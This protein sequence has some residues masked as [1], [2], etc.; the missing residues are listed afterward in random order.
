LGDTTNGILRIRSEAAGAGCLTTL[1]ETT[2]ANNPQLIFNVA[3]LPV[4]IMKFRPSNVGTNNVFFA[5]LAATTDGQVADPNP[6]IGFTN[7]GGTTWTGRTT[8]GGVSANVA[9]TGQ[10]ISTANFALAKIEVVSATKI[11]FFIDNNVTDGINFTE[12]G[13]STT[14]IY[15]SNLAPQLMYQVRTGGTIN[16][17]LEVDY[18]R[19][20]QDDSIMI[21]EAGPE[22]VEELPVI[23]SVDEKIALIEG[24]LAT[25]TA[26]VAAVRLDLN[27]QNV[28]IATQQVKID[29]VVNSVNV[30]NASLDETKSMLAALDIRITVTE[31]RLDVD[32]AL[33][34]DLRTVTDNLTAQMAGLVSSTA[35]GLSVDLADTLSANS[36]YI[37]D[38][39]VFTGNIS[40][41]K[42]ATFSEDMVGQAKILAGHVS[43]TVSFTEPYSSL[44]IVSVTPMD[45]DGRWELSSVTE[46]SFR[47][48]IPE[49]LST[50]VLFNWYAFGAD[51]KAKVFVSDGTTTTIGFKIDYIPEVIPP[52]EEIVPTEEVPA[53][54][55]T[56]EG[57]IEPAL[58][59]ESLIVENPVET[60]D[61]TSSAESAITTADVA[62]AD[63]LPSSPDGATENSGSASGGSTTEAPAGS[64][65][66]APADSQ[67][68][69]SP[70]E[71]GL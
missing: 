57:I 9:C 44:P 41:G 17:Q 4:I 35:A 16:N 20:W 58:E 7:N 10:T 28:L 36:L 11:N 37:A 46:A 67:P 3:N 19:A 43:T 39:A 14:N 63:P 21:S 12:C 45:Y 50:D 66:P 26:D 70:A 51:G 15:T 34:S 65:E 55:S 53:V 29:E 18:Y 52:S 47:I 23:L 31:D 62:A 24:M 68:A 30:L 60:P 5:G 13:S 22:V 61:E 8:N 1:D 27:E 48:E 38:A 56:D 25:T 69:A 54:L 71:P 40:V 33:L 6:F 42:H 2:L 64:S 32:D 59:E 49:I